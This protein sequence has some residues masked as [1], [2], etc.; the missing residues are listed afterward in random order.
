MHL[1]FEERSLLSAHGAEIC[2]RFLLLKTQM[3]TS[4]AKDKIIIKRVKIDG[5][6]QMTGNRCVFR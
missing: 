6:E 3:R 2:S 5:R 1:C 4:N